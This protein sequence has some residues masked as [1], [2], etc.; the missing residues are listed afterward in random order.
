MIFLECFHLVLKHSIATFVS[1][2]KIHKKLFWYIENQVMLYDFTTV[3]DINGLII[4]TDIFRNCACFF[5]QERKHQYRQLELNQL[6]AQNL[7]YRLR[8]PSNTPF[9]DNLSIFTLT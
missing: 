6:L 2:E 3:L 8:R 7:D 4:Q 9:D 5:F 1:K